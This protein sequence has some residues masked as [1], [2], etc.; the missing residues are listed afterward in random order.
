MEHKVATK[1]KSNKRTLGL[2][3]ED[4]RGTMTQQ[5]LQALDHED[6]HIDLV[7]KSRTVQMLCLE[8]ITLTLP[9]DYV[10]MMQRDLLEKKIQLL[11]RVEE[12][13]GKNYDEMRV[14]TGLWKEYQMTDRLN[15]MLSHAF[16]SEEIQK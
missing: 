13:G 4:I 6:S 11:A 15:D 14:P 9:Y 5:Q 3:E 7:T 1:S 8:G 12:N 10:K 16:A 2:K